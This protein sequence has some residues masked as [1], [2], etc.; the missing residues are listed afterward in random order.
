MYTA[1]TC[2]LKSKLECAEKKLSLQLNV[3]IKMCD[4]DIVCS[5]HCQL[6][7]FEIT[8]GES[9]TGCHKSQ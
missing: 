3:K 6:L 5:L 7:L 9:G 4:K 8:Q 1:H 2:T